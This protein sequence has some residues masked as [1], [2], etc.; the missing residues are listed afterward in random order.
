MVKM[1]WSDDIAESARK[2]ISTCPLDHNSED[3]RRLE[4]LKNTYVGQNLAWGYLSWD[5]VIDNWHN[6]VKDFAFGSGSINGKPVGHYT[7]V[8]YII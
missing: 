4:G 1:Y 6:E 8:K 2:W 7:Q 3:E 5:E